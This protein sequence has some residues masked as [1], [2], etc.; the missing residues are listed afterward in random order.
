MNEALTAQTHFDKTMKA[1]AGNTCQVYIKLAPHFA[2][3]TKERCL[4]QDNR[5]I[6]FARGNPSA[7]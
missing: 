3:I 6:D 7:L 4:N 5:H 2:L 1:F